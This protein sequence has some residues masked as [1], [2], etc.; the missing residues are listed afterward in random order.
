MD[1]FSRVAQ[2]GSAKFSQAP[3]W[4]EAIEMH[5]ERMD[6]GKLVHPDGTPGEPGMCVRK[7]GRLS[8]Q[9]LYDPESTAFGGGNATTPYAPGSP[10]P[11]SLSSPSSSSSSISPLSLALSPSRPLS[12]PSC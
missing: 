7:A 2:T 6:R 5:A 4:Q 10:P 12:S 3:L 11:A 8:L 1:A 9:E